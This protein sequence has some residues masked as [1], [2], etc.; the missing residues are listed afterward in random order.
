M[1]RRPRRERA[2]LSK[3]LD[4][5]ARCKGAEVVLWQSLSSNSDPGALEDSAHPGLVARAVFSHLH[6]AKGDPEPQLG[7]ASL[8]A[9]GK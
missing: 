8:T 1:Q 5:K 2:P 3:K 6:S 4:I 7:F 9:A